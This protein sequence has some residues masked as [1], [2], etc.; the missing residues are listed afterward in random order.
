MKVNLSFTWLVLIIWIIYIWPVEYIVASRAKLQQGSVRARRSFQNLGTT[1]DRWKIALTPNTDSSAFIFPNKQFQNIYY[2][3][4]YTI[5]L[6]YHFSISPRSYRCPLS[7]HVLYLAKYPADFVLH[8]LIYSTHWFLRD[9]DIQAVN[10]VC[11]KNTHKNSTPL[12]LPGNAS[13][14]RKNCKRH[15]YISLP[16]QGYRPGSLNRIQRHNIKLDS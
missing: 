12:Q 10:L 4:R 3:C 5:S 11:W 13:R 9:E 2:R 15:S 7:K 1:P 6:I 16:E 8:N 14:R